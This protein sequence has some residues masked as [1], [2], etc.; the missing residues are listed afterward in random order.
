MNPYFFKR[1]FGLVEALIG[2]SLTLIVFL[3]IFG[4]YQ[5]GLKAIMQSRNKI[6]ATAIANGEIEKIRN[7]A[8][9]SVGV[10][11]SFPS[12]ILL[13]SSTKQ[14]NNNDYTI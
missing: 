5:L 4:A 8:Y 12:G 2:V 11:G 7:L 14:Q 13:A 1:G 3:G 6:V 9:G 10:V